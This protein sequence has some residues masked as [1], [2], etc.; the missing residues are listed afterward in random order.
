MCAQFWAHNTNSSIVH[1]KQ[2]HLVVS[3]FTYSKLKYGPLRFISELQ[4]PILCSKT[5]IQTWLAHYS[6]V[7]I[8]VSISMYMIQNGGWLL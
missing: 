7:K 2:H 8:Y 3:S 6:T 4:N 1:G 5:L